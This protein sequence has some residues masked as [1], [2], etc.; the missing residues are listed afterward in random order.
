MT[1]QA[2]AANNYESVLS[3]YDIFKPEVANTLYMQHGD[4]GLP[5]FQLLRSM[6]MEEPVAR[7]D[8]YLHEDNYIHEI[9]HSRGLVADPG[10]GNPILITLAA[11]D[12]DAS[13]RYYPRV[14]DIVTFPNEAVGMITLIDTTIPAA[15]VLTIT[16]VDTNYTLGGVAANAELIIT[17]NAFGEGSGQPAGAVRGT[18]K[19]HYYAQTFKETAV[20]SGNEMVSQLWFQYYDDNNVGNWYN[21]AMRDAE[22]RLALRIDGAFWTGRALNNAALV[23]PTNG[24][25]PYMTTGL[26]PWIRDFGYTYGYTP[27]TF[28]PTDFDQLALYLTRQRITAPNVMFMHGVPLGQEIENALVLYNRNTGVDFTKQA[29]ASLFGGNE[30]LAMSVGFKSLNKGGR[31]F[32]FKNLENF[33][34]PKTF[35][36]TGYNYENM[37]VVIPLIKT[38]T[39]MGENEVP[40]L[41]DI[42]SV[43]YRSHS[44]Y[45]RMFEV[46]DVGGAGVGLK[47][48]DLDLRKHYLRAHLGLQ[49]ATP[50]KLILVDPS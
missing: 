32:H 49:V 12:L 15:P 7:N 20:A 23:D 43:R 42:L 45:N 16:P 3:M 39:A 8:W 24:E 36:A 17:S 30:K 48:T 33:S 25:S 26:I 5:L 13:N 47:T 21:V 29:A 14:S 2:I 46:W 9:F 31:T 11:G 10:A 18:T 40:K 44:N 41:T 4:Q 38:K 37:G 19:R 28:A 50:N 34:N 27:G 22:Y 35:G 1:P 6:G